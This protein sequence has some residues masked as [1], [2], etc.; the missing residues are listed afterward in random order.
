MSPEKHPRRRVLRT[1]RASLSISSAAHAERSKDVD[2]S[3]SGMIQS[4]V[5]SLF[6]FYR[7]RA[8]EPSQTAFCAGAAH[9]I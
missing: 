6:G 3:V 9:P 5:D 7:G 8:W 2:W 4:H 1:P